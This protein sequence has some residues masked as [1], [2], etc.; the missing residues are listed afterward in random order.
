ML[1]VRSVFQAAQMH[2]PALMQACRHL[3]SA[4]AGSNKVGFIGLGHMVSVEDAP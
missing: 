2:M 4:A 1:P 3:S